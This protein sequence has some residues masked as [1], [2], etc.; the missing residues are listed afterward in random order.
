MN[1]KDAIIAAIVTT[2]LGFAFGSIIKVF[3][4]EQRVESQQDIL[5]EIRTDVREIRRSL[6]AP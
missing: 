2:S 5:R 6:N 1:L 4:L 3:A